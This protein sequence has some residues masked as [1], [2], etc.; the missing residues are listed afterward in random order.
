MVSFH[1]TSS[2]VKEF[3]ILELGNG[4]LDLQGTTNN[5]I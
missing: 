2:H 5:R 1:L 3:G 4:V